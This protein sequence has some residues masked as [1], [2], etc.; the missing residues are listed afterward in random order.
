MYRSP[1]PGDFHQ[2]QQL[3]THSGESAMFD[4]E[5]NEQSVASESKGDSFGS[6]GQRGY[7]NVKSKLMAMTLEL[8]VSCQHCT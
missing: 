4:W 7:E 5:R 2:N 3:K 1:H 6:R 8:E